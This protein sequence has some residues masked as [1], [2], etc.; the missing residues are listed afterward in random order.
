M[1]ER[2]NDR[3]FR[4]AANGQ[5]LTVLEAAAYLK[6]TPSTV[7]KWCRE[8]ILPAV[9]LGKVWRISRPGIERMV[10]TGG[11]LRERNEG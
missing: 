5:F 4:A 8:G 11:P 6:A 9:K 7:A 2:P 3:E 1:S 10:S